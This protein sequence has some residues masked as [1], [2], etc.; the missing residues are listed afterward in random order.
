VD[1]NYQAHRTTD[2]CPNGWQNVRTEPPFT[3]DPLE[4]QCQAAADLCRQAH[5]PDGIGV[6]TEVGLPGIAH[7][8]EGEWAPG[9]YRCID[10][11]DSPTPVL[12]Q[13]ELRRL[14]LPPA[15]PHVEPS[16]RPILV[17]VPTNVYA[18]APTITL[19]T[20]ILGQP[21]DVQATPTT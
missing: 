15:T 10:R 6:V 21:I 20:T 11:A 2:L 13:T 3:L 12:T 17:N 7:P 19:H 9:S 4:V 14:P 8:E 1:A 16:N 5:K 18:D